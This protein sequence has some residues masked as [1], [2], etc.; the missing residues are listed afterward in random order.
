MLLIL[1]WIVASA[2]ALLLLASLAVA[3]FDNWEEVLITLATLACLSLIVW[4]IIYLGRNYKIFKTS[5]PP[6]TTNLVEQP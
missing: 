6:V 3:V 5:P 1:A 4:S 2:T